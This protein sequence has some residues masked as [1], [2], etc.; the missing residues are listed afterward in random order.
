MKENT[1]NQK[2]KEKK[3]WQHLLIIPVLLV[4]DVIALAAAGVA[5]TK[6]AGENLGHPVPVFF[7]AVLI[8]GG[9]I[10]VVLIIRALILCLKSLRKRNDTAEESSAGQIKPVWRCFIP[11][12]IEIP[13]AVMAVAICAYFEISS[14]YSNPVHVGFAVP[15]ATFL[16]TGICLL[17]IIVTGIICLIAAAVRRNRN[18]KVI[19]TIA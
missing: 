12:M 2:T 19:N 11:L 16:L 15:V 18:K 6:H 13:V 17:V 1:F 7:M 10:N 8:I 3:W 5:D 14:F 9:V 4:V